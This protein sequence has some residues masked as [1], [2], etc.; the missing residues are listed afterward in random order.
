RSEGCIN[1]SVDGKRVR[2]ATGSNSE[3]LRL[4]SWDVDELKGKTARIEIVDR[5]IRGG[6][7]IS[8]AHNAHSGQQAAI[9]DERTELL[10]AAEASVSTMADRASQD[11][12]R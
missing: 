2:T 6:G 3:H 8:V 1:L 4:R 12:S 11:K 5:H 7:H 10:T 9:P